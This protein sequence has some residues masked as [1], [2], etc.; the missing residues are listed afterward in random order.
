M[1]AYPEQ[2]PPLHSNS[3]WQH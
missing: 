1:A 3:S 2:A